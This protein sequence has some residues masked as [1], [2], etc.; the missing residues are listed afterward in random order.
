MK[1]ELYQ[2]LIV[3]LNKREGKS[4]CSREGK[5]RVRSYDDALFIL[6]RVQ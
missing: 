3:K 1:I 5:A 2:H 6:N 4:I